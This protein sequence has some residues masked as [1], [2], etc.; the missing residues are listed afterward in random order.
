MSSKQQVTLTI[1]GD[2]SKLKSAFDEVGQASRDMSREVAAAGD[3]FDR[4]GE[5]ADTVDTRS[6]GFRD[7]LTGVE[8]GMK[9]IK[10]ATEDG[11]GFES[12]LLLGTGVGDLASGFFNFLVPS[13][14]SAVTWLGQ[15][16]VG[17]LAAAAAQKVAE[18]GSKAWAGAQWLLNA[19]MTANPIGLVVLAIVALVAIVVLIATKTTWFQDLWRAVWSRIGDPVKAA[20]DWIRKT[21]TKAFDWYLSLPGKIGSAFKKVGGFISAPFRAGFNAISRAWNNTV[22]RLSWS[23][24]GWVPGIGGNSISVPNLPTFHSGTSAVP[25]RPGE[26]VLA[27]LQAGEQVRSRSASMGGG[28]AVIELNSS[29]S[30]LDDL[31]LEVLR[32]SIR[33]RG[34]NVQVVLGGAR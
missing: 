27:V 16:K 8:D 17:T 31:L 20:W 26:N 18:L 32:R 29:G 25:G 10:M 2:A 13:L 6:M 24:P 11:L 5:A 3:G 28:V 30:R 23:V 21:T 12:L 1:A 33:V 34:G 14:K 9:G 4:V 15:T 22:G 19:A 7:T